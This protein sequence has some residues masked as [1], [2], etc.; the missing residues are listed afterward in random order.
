MIKYIDLSK[1]KY[2]ALPFFNEEEA[3]NVSSGKGWSYSYVYHLLEL[4]NIF[5][6]LKRIPYINKNK[7]FEEAIKSGLPYVRTEWD[8]RRVL[9]L[10]N[11]LVNFNLI[12][13]DYNIEI[14]YFPEDE[15]SSCLT[16]DDLTIFTNIY[17]Q[18]FRFKEIHSWLLSPSQQNHLQFIN[19]ITPHKL[20]EQSKPIFPFLINSRFYNAFIFELKNSTG[21][22]KISEDKGNG[23]NGALMRFVDVYIKWGQELGLIEKFNMKNLDYE[24]SNNLKS[25]SCLYYINSSIPTFNLLDFIKKHYQGRHIHIPNLVLKI[26]LEYRYS[27]SVIREY[28]IKQ[29]IEHLEKLSLQRTS[30][31]FIRNTEIDFVPKYKGS[32]VSHLLIQ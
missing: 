24:L 14:N 19:L 21:V 3:K 27:L 7:F 8:S 28:V 10:I 6:A 1:S 2:Y 5:I 25:F 13:R 29:A 18:Y 11:A 12:T 16:A 17:H 30:E 4:K 20:E 22:Y 15:Y 26:A 9:E 31:I 23:N 32:Y